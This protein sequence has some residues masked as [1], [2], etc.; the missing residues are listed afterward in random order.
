MEK[1]FGNKHA[2]TAA[3]AVAVKTPLR[4]LLAGWLGFFSCGGNQNELRR[5]A[6]N[7]AADDA[8][9]ALRSFANGKWQMANGN[10]RA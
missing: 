1:R 8:A 2:K 10:T 6:V 5:K 9:A 3:A 4:K 7:T